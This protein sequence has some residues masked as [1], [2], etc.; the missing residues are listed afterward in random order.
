MSYEDREKYSFFSA[1]NFP[2]KDEYWAEYELIY[3]Y[4]QF[5][6]EYVYCDEPQYT[7]LQA[8]FAYQAL[9]EEAY[10]ETIYA[11]LLKGPGSYL[12]RDRRLLHEYFWREP[13]WTE[14]PEGSDYLP[15]D[16]TWDD[17]QMTI[18]ND[19]LTEYAV[20]QRHLQYFTDTSG[21]PFL[22]ATE[23]EGLN[24]SDP[25]AY[26]VD[27]AQFCMLSTY[28]Y[29]Y[30]V[31]S[32][33]NFKIM[34]RQAL[35][36]AFTVA[37][38]VIIAGA[39]NF[40]HGVSVGTATW[41]IAKKIPSE[42]L[43]EMVT[44]LAISSVAKLLGVSDPI[45]EQLGESL[46]E[47]GVV[48]NMRNLFHSPL[49]AYSIHK[50]EINQAIDVG[51]LSPKV[52]LA[53]IN[54]KADFTLLQ[55]TAMAL[56]SA[57]AYA[58]TASMRQ[59]IDLVQGMRTFCEQQALKNFDNLMENLHT[60]QL[61]LDGKYRDFKGAIGGPKGVIST[62]VQH[63]WNSMDGLVD[64]FLASPEYREAVNCPEG[65]YIRF[66]G[67]IKGYGE[68]SIHRNKDR[69]WVYELTKLNNDVIEME[70][71]TLWEVT[72]MCD[73]V[74]MI[75]PNMPQGFSD[76]DFDIDD[77]IDDFS[78]KWIDNNLGQMLIPSPYLI[79]SVPVGVTQ[80]TP[81][82][83]YSVQR[84]I[85]Q[86]ADSLINALINS[87]F[88]PYQRRGQTPFTMG[89]NFPAAG[90]GSAATRDQ[91]TID[92]L[93]DIK[94]YAYYYDRVDSDGTSHTSGISDEVIS[95]NFR[96]ISNIYDSTIDRIE[97]TSKIGHSLS[98]METINAKVYHTIL[99]SMELI[100]RK[101]PA[102]DNFYDISQIGQ[103]R[104]GLVNPTS[105]G[106]FHE[107][108][109]EISSRLEKYVPSMVLQEIVNNG[110]GS[111][112]LTSS[113][114][115][116]F[117]NSRLVG[118]I[119]SLGIVDGQSIS[120][121]DWLLQ[122]QSPNIHPN[123]FYMTED[124]FKSILLHDNC[125]IGNLMS[126]QESSILA[127]TYTSLDLFKNRDLSWINTFI[128]NIKYEIEILDTSS[129][130]TQ[131]KRHLFQNRF[132]IWEQNYKG[133]SKNHFPLAALSNYLNNYAASILG[134]QEISMFESRRM[135]RLLLGHP[136][137]FP[138]Y[139]M[140]QLCAQDKI[141]KFFGGN[142][143]YFSA[144]QEQYATNGFQFLD[145]SPFI[146]YCDSKYRIYRFH[147]PWGIHV[148]TETLSL[149]PQYG[150]GVHGAASELATR[151]S[152]AIFQLSVPYNDGINY[153]TA[154]N[155][156]EMQIHMTHLVETIYGTFEAN[157]FTDRFVPHGNELVQSVGTK[158]HSRI[159]VDRYIDP[160]SSQTYIILD[161]AY[162]VY[163]KDK[164]I[165][166]YTGE[167]LDETRQ[168]NKNYFMQKFI[169][170]EE[171]IWRC[172][173]VDYW[174]KFASYYDSYMSE[175]GVIGHLQPLIER[176]FFSI[177]NDVLKSSVS[178]TYTR[179]ET[180]QLLVPNSNQW[181]SDEF[182][183]EE[184]FQVFLAKL[185]Q[186][187][188]QFLAKYG[189]N[190]DFSELD[191]LDNDLVK[192][193]IAIIIA[194]SYGFFED[195]Q[196]PGNYILQTGIIKVKKLDSHGNV[197]T[198]DDAQGNK[199]PELED[200]LVDIR[201]YWYFTE[202][203]NEP[204]ILENM[205]SFSTYQSNYFDFQLH[206]ELQS[207]LLDMDLSSVGIAIGLIM[208]GEL[209]FDYVSGQYTDRNY[210]FNPWMYWYCKRLERIILDS[211]L[212]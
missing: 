17:P 143:E 130:A 26:E 176:E 165:S 99:P 43:Q 134:L 71:M 192:E 109:R 67:V 105:Y 20:S 80:Q 144:I 145:E 154:K 106:V 108:V 207:L 185:P 15:Y 113:L 200:H 117:L 28:Y 138:E 123:W 141:D 30:D 135:E 2:Q 112:Y 16:P 193:E 152:R 41:Q 100:K 125:R 151:T 178:R 118:P 127:G 187:K 124:Q 8:P 7:L 142:D 177:M 190:P 95:P 181:I 84:G 59:T 155:N 203:A 1:D 49:S 5:L 75:D 206:P 50:T 162:Q 114:N 89:S 64:Q 13:T 73:S 74:S 146:N 199:L 136:M 55:K 132:V 45:A 63:A 68:I 24:Y 129:S 161:G 23:S 86:E 198:Y 191:A 182:I 209:F 79:S 150:L 35:D 65:K 87:N 194:N 44:E 38:G 201:L 9:C 120:V 202:H 119:S 88:I 158:T 172:N 66:V 78:E 126:M 81:I 31:A 175:Y 58:K 3:P 183:S 70:P 51:I 139:V 110:Y 92:M 148:K 40:D 121:K 205:I 174:P 34:T 82:P 149:D 48:S 147:M 57:S 22:M 159:Y 11:T 196:N 56:R 77:F 184:Y 94:N 133:V 170:S 197:L 211:E 157:K 6:S 72:Q 85:Q 188:Y 189:F 69:Q 115:Q 27:Y 164:G 42:L 47:G 10:E 102:S 137:N 19:Q 18:A 97:S 83:K 210:Q 204:G 186:F 173:P 39:V 212:Q 90:I 140:M 54:E 21:R 103:S 76:D 160:L 91:F 52:T 29:Y 153:I 168:S 171:Y 101:M 116:D 60:S 166:V 62:T 111:N 4:A 122:I 36:Q 163:G 61:F 128:S 180:I 179:K 93:Y 104:F 167:V 156:E 37:V 53:L 32:K 169:N 131:R 46:A 98:Q 107:V 208:P 14:A 96:E 33:Y 12:A 25:I 195:L